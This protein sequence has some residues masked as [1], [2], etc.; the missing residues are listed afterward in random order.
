MKLCKKLKQMANAAAAQTALD[1][2]RKPFVDNPESVF[3]RD[4]RESRVIAQNFVNAVF[5]NE[6][7]QLLM[8]I[9][10]LDLRRVLSPDHDDALIGFVVPDRADRVVTKILQQ[11]KALTGFTAQLFAQFPQR[12]GFLGQ[13][14]VHTSS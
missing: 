2:P 6:G 14:T 11:L 9:A 13:M 5:A 8:D 7:E 10:E 3:G 12:V 1:G 4:G